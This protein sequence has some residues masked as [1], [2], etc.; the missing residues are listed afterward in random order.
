MSP[1]KVVGCRGG[2]RY[3]E[4]GWFLGKAERF[5][6]MILQTYQDSTLVKISQKVLALF[7]NVKQIKNA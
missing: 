4:G 2:S 7:K 1:K 3:F 6:N 5:K